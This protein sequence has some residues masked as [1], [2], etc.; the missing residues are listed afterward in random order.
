MSLKYEEHWIIVS[1]AD[2]FVLRKTLPYMQS[3]GC[4]IIFI[5]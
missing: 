3:L 2:I 4:V 1:I 5:I